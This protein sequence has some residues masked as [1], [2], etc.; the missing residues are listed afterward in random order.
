MKIKSSVKQLTI[1]QFAVTDKLNGS[2]RGKRNDK[3]T[4]KKRDQK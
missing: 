1:F 4:D 3:S 2:F